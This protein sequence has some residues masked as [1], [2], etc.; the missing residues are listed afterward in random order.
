MKYGRAYSSSC[1]HV[2]CNLIHFVTIHSYASGNR[3]KI[4]K[5]LYFCRSASFKVID[6]DTTKKH[7]TSACYLSSMYVPMCKRFH[8]RQANSGKITTF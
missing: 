5:T 7:V 8:A 3:K 2:I 4:T 6:A 1:S